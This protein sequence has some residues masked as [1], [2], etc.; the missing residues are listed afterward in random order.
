M[1]SV[2]SI[3]VCAARSRILIRPLRPGTHQV[4]P[5]GHQPNTSTPLTSRCWSI[6]LTSLRQCGSNYDHCKAEGQFFIFSYL[7]T[8]IGAHRSL[9]SSAQN[10]D[11]QT[12]KCY[13]Y[14]WFNNLWIIVSWCFWWNVFWGRTSFVLWSTIFWIS[15]NNNNLRTNKTL[16]AFISSCLFRGK[17]LW[18][19]LGR[20]KLKTSQIKST[21]VERLVNKERWAEEEEE[22]SSQ[23]L[24]RLPVSRKMFPAEYIAGCWTC[25]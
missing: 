19:T 11:F 9:R 25:S 18:D 2:Q 6:K 20:Q 16:M 1:E 12:I 21:D 23:K 22:P 14:R 5:H 8:L 24:H 4:G 17:H 15:V 7:A 10:F 13:I 3:M